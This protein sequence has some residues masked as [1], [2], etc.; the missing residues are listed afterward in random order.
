MALGGLSD[1]L[2]AVIVLRYY[3]GRLYAEVNESLGIPIGRVKSRL[4]LGFR[5]L[6]QE[7][8]K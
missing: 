6:R 3:G 4:D 5:K 7:P 8:G 1:K 2:R